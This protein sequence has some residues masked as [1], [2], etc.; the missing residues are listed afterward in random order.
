MSSETLVA[1]WYLWNPMSSPL[2]F[3]PSLPCPH[4][5]AFSPCLGQGMI[6]GIYWLEQDH[7]SWPVFRSPKSPVV[8]T[9]NLALELTRKCSQSA[10]PSGFTKAIIGREPTDKNSTQGYFRVL[11]ACFCCRCT[12]GQSGGLSLSFFICSLVIIFKYKRPEMHL[13]LEHIF[14][15]FNNNLQYL[16]WL[17]PN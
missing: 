16:Y 15:V 14:P 10:A 1:T 6:S 2:F 13:L 17:F 12:C 3:F 7:I 8:V 4:H 5:G 11:S 9:L